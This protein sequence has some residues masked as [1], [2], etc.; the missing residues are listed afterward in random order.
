MTLRARCLGIGLGLTLFAG[1]AWLG[2]ASAQALPDPTRLED[3]IRLFEAQ[4]RIH[5]PPRSAI[6]LTGSSSIARWNGEAPAAL[7][8]LTVIPRGFGGS[9]M[10]DVLHYLD[11]VALA[12]EPRAILIYEGDNDTGAGTPIPNALIL[13]QLEQIIARVHEVLP[14]T[15]IYVLSVKPSVLRWGVW[16]VAQALSAGYREIADR[17]PLVHYVDV[18]TPLLNDD[19]SVMMDIF[20]EDGLHLNDRGNAIWG[21]TIK[22]A[23]MPLEARYEQ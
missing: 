23:L 12:Y 1:A 5:A 15:R 9:V 4:D 13:A 21:A 10:N 22:A 8:P 2:Q 7:A 16:P 3:A 14:E 11:R 20:I 18:A 17:D 6:V 19:G